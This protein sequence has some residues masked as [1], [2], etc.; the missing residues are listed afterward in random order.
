[1]GNTI[2]QMGNQ[3]SKTVPIKIAN[4][5]GMTDCMMSRKGF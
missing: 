4:K 2:T 5:A 3:E 1:L